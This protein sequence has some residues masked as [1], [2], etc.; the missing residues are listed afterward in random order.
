M[1]QWA[2]QSEPLSI[3]AKGKLNDDGVDSEMSAELKYGDNKVGQ[4]KTS[5][6]KTQ[7][8]L[9][10]I[11]GTKGTMTV[12]KSVLVFSS[13]KLFCKFAYLHFNLRFM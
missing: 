8:N 6:L 10:K 13:L 11:V 4:I 2:F 7:N 12:N 5:G 9:A 1:C 3:T